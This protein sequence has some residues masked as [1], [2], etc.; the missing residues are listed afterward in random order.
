MISAQ[1]DSV[2]RND[3]ALF[4]EYKSPT[5]LTPYSSNA[6]THSKR[7]IRQIAESICAFGFTNP[8]LVDLNNR[9]VAGHGRVEAAKLL[10]MEQIPTIRLESLSEE[11]IRA[12]VIADNKLAENAGWD[13]YILAIELVF[14]FRKGKGPHRNNI[15]L[16]QFGRN[17][18][19][20]WQYP[21]VQTLSKQGGEGNLLALHPTV[22][23]TA[24]Q[25]A[26]NGPKG[27][28]KPT[29]EYEKHQ[30][31]CSIHRLRNRK[32]TIV[33]STLSV[34]SADEY[35]VIL[36]NDLTS[37]IERSFYELNPQATFMHSPYIELLAAALERCRN[38][39]TKRLI[40]NLPPRTLKSHAV[41]CCILSLAARA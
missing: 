25:Y 18:T 7:Q 31:R 37:F 28:G 14:V 1:T 17:R 12:Y 39:K 5:A 27:N 38:G 22:K 13:R 32:D 34:L 35:Q 40:I 41:E 6:R 29:A 36:R 23:P 24:T 20:V 2:P 19:N 26:R 30:R 10:G 15:Q 21:G 9:I 4:V 16:G 11:Q 3:I 33:M 8:V